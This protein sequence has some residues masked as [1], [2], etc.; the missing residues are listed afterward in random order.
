MH[1]VK[2]SLLVLDALIGIQIDMTIKNYTVKVLKNRELK[3]RR[4]RAHIFMCFYLFSLLTC[5]T[6]KFGDIKTLSIQ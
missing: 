4:D 2:I 6:V 3:G 5:H 1:K